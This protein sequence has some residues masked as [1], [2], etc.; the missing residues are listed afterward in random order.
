ME[1]QGS[2]LSSIRDNHS[3]GTVGQFL[4]EKIKDDTELSIVSAFFTIYAYDALKPEL[5]K[6]KSLRFLYGDPSFTGSVDPSKGSKK[7]F[8]IEDENIELQNILQQRRIARDCADWISRKAEIKSVNKANFL[9]GKMYH[10]N[11]NGIEDA[12]IG[13]SNF[14]T[15]GLGLSAQKNIE[16]N[17]EVDSRRDRQDLKEW[18]D[19]LWNNPELIKD[20]KEEVLRYLNELYKDYEPQFIYYK[21]LYHLFEKYINEQASTDLLTEGGTI[22]DT[23][24]WNTLF[25]FQKDAV[26]SAINKINKHNGC[27]IADSV[28]L[29]KT[30][31][32]LAII[33]YF[34][35]KNFRVLVLCPK[36]LKDNWTVFQAHKGNKLNWFENDRF[37]YSVLYHT[38][39]SRSHGVSDADGI[40]LATF[41]WG[42]F[43]LVVVDESHNFRNDTKGKKDEDGNI[44]RRSRYERMLHEIIGSGVKT[45]VL[46]LSATPVNTNL[47]DLRN[48]I[49]I[50]TDDQDRAFFE[51][52]QINSVSDT[53]KLAQTQFTNWAKDKQKEGI[54]SKE[55]LDKLDSSLFKLLD[56]LTISRSRNHIRKYY[57][58]EMEKI[59][60]FPE[61]SKAIPVYSEID[62]KG[63]FLSYDRLQDEIGKYELSMFKPSAYVKKEFKSLY[64]EKAKTIGITGFLQEDR[65]K[66][67][68]GMMKM[69]FLKRLE[70]SVESFEITMMRCV[71]KI[72][73]LENKIREYNN[74]KVSDPEFDID[75]TRLKD[76]EDD[77]LNEIYTVGKKLKYELKHLNLDDWLLALKND[78][79]QLSI[80]HASAESVTPERDLKL[81]ELKKLISEKIE[82]PSKN[83][84]GKINRKV[85]IFT[86][87]ADT[88]FYL[89]NNI[90]YWALN[91][92]HVHSAI[93]TGGS[94]GNK[95]NFQPKG[96]HELT[97]YNHILTNFS[98]VSKGRAKLTIEMPQDDEVDILIATDC[99]SEGQNLQDCD[100][101]INYDIHWNP[102]RVI[103]RFGRID[104]IGSL[105]EVIHLINF[106]PTKDLD[107][108]INLKY[109][110]E[111][112]M[113]L[114]DVTATNEDNVL[115]PDEIKDLVETELRYRDKQLLR[116]KDEILEMDDLN[117]N[118]PSLSEFTLD[119]FRIDLINFLQANKEKLENAPFGIYALTECKID[120][121]ELAEKT[122]DIIQPGVIF[123]LKQ[124][125]NAIS[126]EKV[127][128]LQPYFLAYVRNN[129]DIRFSFTQP[130]QILE[131]YRLLCSNRDKVAE[132]LCRI[133]N[134][135]TSDGKDMS[136]YSSLLKKAVTNISKLLNKR[137]EAQLEGRSGK[138]L[139]ISD[140]PR[141][142]DDFELITWL[143]IK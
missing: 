38:D 141:F 21:T 80:L 129:G 119:D 42:A 126:V 104:R 89:Y 122:K 135:E 45:K 31:E 60:L 24:I 1:K 98:P 44:I 62:S 112:R 101:L 132:K 107:K 85:L 82:T 52:L 7:V 78:K 50:I 94:G 66:F 53:L 13:S 18:F 137:N 58:H 61:R 81:Q 32:A 76:E 6:I 97:E 75:D 57:A 138:L 40:N 95:T 91:N 54:K 74:Q 37:S 131:L 14:T 110:V 51:T 10:I 20:V 39:L 114:V 117:E 90:A 68:I 134:D 92:L 59:G 64:A 99:I 120:N 15:R 35:L 128:P 143:I 56:E 103:Q 22:A 55:L 79:E 69:N 87:F 88:A 4:K 140:L 108:Y 139:D 115:N 121:V 2:S 111:A 5:E 65:E 142:E 109:R 71:N 29:G 27:I 77:E 72:E 136:A 84:E 100:Y 25:D 127:N 83:R 106:W 130:K 28:G 12:I 34:E 63:W 11:N 105:N 33:K 102:V 93:V 96:F 133:F 49:R 30:F 124:K 123:C 36:K 116:M 46:L 48:Q 16:L 113:A 19:S 41:N 47:K 26:K 86:A 70:S 8:R 67:L 118:I 9:H 73:D 125:Q 23:Q 3:H 43:D 17:L